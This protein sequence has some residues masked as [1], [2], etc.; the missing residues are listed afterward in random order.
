MS[1][2]LELAAANLLTPMMLCFALGLIAALSRSQMTVP[3]AAARPWGLYLLC[4]IG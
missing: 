3:V 2:V 4:A 1:D